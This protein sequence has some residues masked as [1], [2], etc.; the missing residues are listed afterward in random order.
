MVRREGEVVKETVKPVSEI[1]EV[2]E[3]VEVVT[4][5]EEVI[6]NELT[7]EAE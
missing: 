4:E 7:E 3:Q 5:I 6:E 1:V 2:T